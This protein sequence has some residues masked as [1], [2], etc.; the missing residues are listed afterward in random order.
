M[1]WKNPKPRSNK[2][3]KR[4]IPAERSRKYLHKISKIIKEKCPNLLK[5]MPIKVQ[6]AYRTSNR[7]DQNRKFP[8]HITETTLN[9]NITKQN[10]KNFKRKRANI[11][12]KQ[13]YGDSKSQ[14]NL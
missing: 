10:I 9:K 8:H 13:T 2:Y 3:R 7:L 1:A 6:V 11:I 5:G 12:Y 4:R 14:M